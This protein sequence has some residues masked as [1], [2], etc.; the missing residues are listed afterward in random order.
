MTEHYPNTMSAEDKRTTVMIEAG[1]HLSLTKAPYF[2][3]STCHC[4][5]LLSE[6]MSVCWQGNHTCSR[7]MPESVRRS[8]KVLQTITKPLV[9][10]TRHSLGPRLTPKAVLAISQ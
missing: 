8:M 5:A 1:R 7:V 3:W 4:L 10:I 9:E 2:V 6:P